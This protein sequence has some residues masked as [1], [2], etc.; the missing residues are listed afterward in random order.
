[1]R[2]YRVLAV[3]GGGFD[4]YGKGKAKVAFLLTESTR[5]LKLRFRDVEVDGM[6]ATEKLLEVIEVLGGRE[7]IDLVMSSSVPVAGFNLLDAQQVLEK[8]A[9]PTVFFL[10]E[11]PDS[12][13]VEGA[14]VKHFAD[15]QKRIE[16]LKRAG[17][18]ME[19]VSDEAPVW[20]E[21]IGLSFEDALAASEHLTVFGR[22]PEP[23]RIAK[24][25]ARAATSL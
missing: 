7:E 10:R 24:M 3:E 19:F 9:V 18:M 16:V 23:L 12:R 17:P 20:L 25:A 14:L 13:A 15:N 22:V 5:P 8:F 6:D 11:M 1:M 4:K 21:C 2:R